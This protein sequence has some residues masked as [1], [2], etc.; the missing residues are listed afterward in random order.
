MNDDFNDNNWAKALGIA[1]GTA[2]CLGDEKMKEA[3][4]VE[5]TTCKENIL[6]LESCYL[7][8]N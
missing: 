8:D 1:Y 4:L 6:Y 2:S 3:I 7:I 5:F